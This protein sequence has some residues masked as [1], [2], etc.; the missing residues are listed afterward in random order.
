MRFF[1]KTYDTRKQYPQPGVAT[2][3]NFNTVT[4]DVNALAAVVAAINTN[5]LTPPKGII[6]A[7]LSSAEIVDNFDATGNGVSASYLGWAIC[8]GNNGTPNLASKFIRESV[9]AAGTT[10]GSDTQAAHTHDINHTHG[11]NTSGNEAAHTHAA[12][13]FLAQIGTDGTYLYTRNETG[14][15]WTSNARQTIGWSITNTNVT[16]VAGIQGSSAAGSSHNH[17]T[18]ALV[19]GATNSGTLAATDNRP[20]YFELVP[21]MKL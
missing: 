20:A 10:G 13:S 6:N 4:A 16:C 15:Q 7:Y 5:A 12:G 2:S 18:P 1:K 11:A 14:S 9:T 21:L 17:S 8:N 19:L 3:T